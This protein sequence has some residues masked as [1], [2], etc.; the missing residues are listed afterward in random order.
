M[1]NKYVLL[2]F[3]LGLGLGIGILVYLKR[4][5]NYLKVEL[6]K[7]QKLENKSLRIIYEIEK[8]TNLNSKINKIIIDK[9]SSTSNS[10]PNTNIDNIIKVDDDELWDIERFDNGSIKSIKIK[11]SDKLITA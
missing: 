6:Q 1:D 3:V 5:D 7:L 11:G 9:L 2:L 4:N 8:Q 10:N